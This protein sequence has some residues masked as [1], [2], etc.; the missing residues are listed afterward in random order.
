MKHRLTYLFAAC[1]IL[2]PAAVSAQQSS[3]MRFEQEEWDFGRIREV[4][5]PVEHTFTFT[6][7]GRQPFVIEK[8]AVSCGCTTPLFSKDPIRPGEQGTLTVRYDPTERPGEFVHDI[9]IGSRKGRNKNVVRIRGEVI[10][11]PRTIEEDYPFRIAGGVRVSQFS[12]Y[13]GTVRQGETKALTVGYVNN[14]LQPATIGYLVEPQRSFIRVE[15]PTTLQPG[16]R[17]VI[18]VTY[19][20]SGEEFFGRYSDR[21]YLTVNGVQELTPISTTFTAIDSAEGVDL[22][23]SP[24]ALISPQF[25]DFGQVQRGESLTL[26]LELTND[27]SKPLIVRW[28]HPRAGVT[29][30]LS[31]GVTVE[32]GEAY[33]FTARIDTSGLGRGINTKSITVITNDPL[34]PVRE[35]RLVANVK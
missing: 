32:P 28:V 31:Q 19:D 3:T 24:G 13:F 33:A 14:S 10:P 34:N 25:H 5:G 15:A 12:L 27:G 1:C 22:R 6:N 21:I 35:I 26:Q 4:D 20:L 30:T 17:G 23:N 29:T 11:R 7:T 16:E 8:V 2:L 18:T 9:H